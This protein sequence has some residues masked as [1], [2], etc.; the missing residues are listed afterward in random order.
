[1]GSNYKFRHQRWL[2]NGL[3]LTLLLCLVAQTACM[4]KGNDSAAQSTKGKSKSLS[5]QSLK[6]KNGLSQSQNQNKLPLIS[7]NG[8]QYVNAKKLVELLGFQNE[9]NADN[10]T[11]LIGDK[12]VNFV[13]KMNSREAQ[14]EED[15]MKL[16]SPPILINQSAY[17][18]LSAVGDLF[19]QDMSYIVKDNQLIVQANQMDSNFS[20]KSMNDQVNGDYL[21]F[22]D[23]PDDPNKQVDQASSALPNHLSIK[24]NLNEEDGTIAVLA[25]IDIPRLVRQSKQYLGVKY[26][27]GAKPYPQSGAFDC[28][29]FTQY[30]FA[31]QGIM[32]KRLSRD[33]AKQGVT[34]SRKSLR[35]GDL[36][37]F[38]VPGRFKSSSIVGHVGI[39]IGNQEM[40]NANTQPKSGVQITNINKPYW[41]RVFLSAKRVAS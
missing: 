6:G 30:M 8:I 34:V 5:I 27:F 31:K 14:K 19:Q 13:L 38:N 9:W 10:S 24:K 40:I 11:Y 28:S 20:I 29:S 41:K 2:R 12:D 25:N 3:I 17:I 7:Q 15:K 26:V 36:L 37:F 23:D 33:Q 4:K 16:A 32:L 21:D 35:I 18:P 22:A 1:V 39:Y